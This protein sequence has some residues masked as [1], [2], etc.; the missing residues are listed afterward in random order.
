MHK[1]FG[2]LVILFSVV[3]SSNPLKATGH[4]GADPADE[5]PKKD[6]IRDEDFDS[7]KCLNL[8]A[9]M[10]AILKA[11][12]DGLKVRSQL[13]DVILQNPKTVITEEWLKENGKELLKPSLEDISDAGFMSWRQIG[14]KR[15]VDTNEGGNSL[16]ITQFSKRQKQSSPRL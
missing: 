8:P 5:A 11:K 7:G 13:V 3:F 4:F 16:I 12:K 10:R 14:C 15:L 2:Y 9:L 6:A 1:Q